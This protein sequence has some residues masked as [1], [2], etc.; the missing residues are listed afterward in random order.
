MPHLPGDKS[1]KMRWHHM[2]KAEALTVIAGLQDR[3]ADVEGLVE[4]IASFEEDRVSIY[5]LIEPEQ[6]LSHLLDILLDED[7]D[8]EIRE[9]VALV[10]EFINSVRYLMPVQARLWLRGW[11]DA[12]LHGALAKQVGLE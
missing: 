3:G 2:S 10:S 12:H 1:W 8:A 9:G 5:W 4:E 6:E 11:V 7:D